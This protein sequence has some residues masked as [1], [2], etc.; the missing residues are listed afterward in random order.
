[1]HIAEA[2]AR[3]VLSGDVVAGTWVRR[4][5]E[6]H[7]YDLRRRDLVWRED[8]ADKA[9]RFVSMLVQ[10][11]GKW[12]GQNLHIQPWEAF[13]IS[14]LFGWYL[15]TGVR[16]FNRADILLG[17]KNG[18]STLAASIC[19]KMLCADG[20]GSPEIYTAATAREQAKIVWGKAEAMVQAT[21]ALARRVNIR[22]NKILFTGK[23]GGVMTPL[24]KDAK[25]AEGIN[26]H[27]AVLDEIHL[28][29]SEEMV[30][31]LN[32]G[33]GARQN[34]LLLMITTEGHDR[35]ADMIGDKIHQTSEQVLTGFKA[36]KK[37]A[38]KDDSWFA[39]LA[40]LD[41]GDAWEDEANWPKANPGL[42]VSP[43]WEEMRRQ[44]TLAK[45][46]PSQINDFKTR[47]L[48]IKTSAAAAWITP[49][50]WD[51]GNAG[52]TLDDMRGRACFV[53]VDM[54][55]TTDFTALAFLFPPQDDAEDWRAR[56][57][58]FVCEAQFQERANQRQIDIAA[59]QRDGWLMVTD[60]NVIDR[61]AVERTLIDV[62]AA[63]GLDIQAVGYD[64]AYMGEVAQNWQDAYGLPVFGV[65][66][67]GITL[68]EPFAK[69]ESLVLA[70]RFL[71]G[72]DPVLRWQ[73]QNLRLRYDANNNPI[74]GKKA[75]ADK[76]DGVAATLNAFAVAINAPQ[77]QYQDWS[78][79]S[80]G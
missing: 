37:D 74:P 71:H 66:Q 36:R 54:S 11:E 53:G 38:V 3:A 56:V 21:P 76:I 8:E 12:A 47:R 55:R 70:G 52:W 60:G 7:L 41:A 24:S 14:S 44:F 17:K 49:E 13:I 58:H 50:I 73:V 32:Q 67:G 31:M 30:N 5:A 4:A 72:G 45:N 23:S 20:E 28:Y 1:M 16:R 42:G 68:V 62:A 63:Y 35:G 25:M 59:W 80:F 69:F 40:R 78:H 34:P 43:N 22:V 18:K 75:S 77:E 26:P 33:F 9:L 57:F 79:I 46:M 6:R 29:G 51:K 65:R 27:C 19:L 15:K 64:P 2:Y 61:R 39:Y 48:N 10:T